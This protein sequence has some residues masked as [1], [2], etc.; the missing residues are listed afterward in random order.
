MDSWDSENLIV[1]VDSVKTQKNF[2]FNY[3]SPNFCGNTYL[4]TYTTINLNV[5]H[6]ASSMVVVISTNLDSGPYDESFGIRDIFILVDFVRWN[7]TFDCFFS[8]KLQL[9]YFYGK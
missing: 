3:F 4:D 5:T 1:S 6:S 8:N 7:E 9:T 2:N